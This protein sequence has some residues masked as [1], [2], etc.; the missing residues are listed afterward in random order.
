M[1]DECRECPEQRQL[2]LIQRV[3]RV[4]Y[5]EFDPT[6]DDVLLPDISRQLLQTLGLKPQGH[7]ISLWS[8]LADGELKRLR[9]SLKQ[10]SEMHKPFSIELR[11][12]K[13]G[14]ESIFLL[15]RGEPLSGNGNGA[16][17]E[18]TFQDISDLKRA[19]IERE[20]IITQFH[21]LLDTL[22]QGISVVDS[23]MRLI[24]WNRRFYEIL[25]FPQHLVYRNAPFA[26]LIRYNAQRG[27]YG[28]GDPEEHVE[29]IMARAA[30]FKPHRFERMK[31]GGRVLLVEGLPFSFG[32]VASGFV[33]C[34]TDITESK[35][36]EEIIAQQRDVM[37]VIIDNFPGG[38]SFCNPDLRFTAYNEQFQQLLEFPPELFAKGWVDFETL[39]RFNVER[40]EYGPGEPEEQ[41]K[42]AVERARNFQ[43][44]RIERQ[45]PNGKWLEIRGAPV[46][47]GGFVTSYIDITERKQIEEELRQ[48]KLA[49]EARREQVASLLDNADQGFLSFGADLVVEAECSR[50]CETM[51]GSWP[52]GKEA[53]ELLFGNDPDGLDLFRETIA[54]VLVETDTLVKEAMLSLLPSGITHGERVLHAQCKLLDKQRVMMVLTDITAQRAMATMLDKERKR[55]EL[56]VAAVTDGGNFFDAVE[57]YRELLTQ[58]LPALFSRLDAPEAMAR[59]AYRVIHTF[60]GLLNQFSFPASPQ[61]LH[62]VEGKL[63]N[64]LCEPN[65]TAERII[66]ATSI[67]TLKVHLSDDLTILSNALGEDFM[68]RG[69]G[70]VLSRASALVLNRL[71]SRLLHGEQVAL[72]EPGLHH[73]LVEVTRLTK[74]SL[75]R[76]LLDFDHF[77]RQIGTRTGKKV[78]RLSVAGDAEI[79]LDPDRYRPFLQSLGHIFRN[80]VV[81]GIESPD[82][83]CDSGKPDAALIRCEFTLENDTIRL[84]IAD[85]GKG[86][87]LPALR[88]KAVELEL[89]PRN[90][91]DAV[92]D[93]EIAQLIF[94]DQVSTRKETDELAG[95]GVGLPAVL[96]ET[97]QLGGDIEIKTTAGEGTAFIFTLPY[98]SEDG[99]SDSNFEN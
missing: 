53:A 64:L 93:L 41:V 31:T 55:Q 45:R 76:A 92:D 7:D 12:I 97:R 21:A 95:R 49:A 62:D 37:K 44:H 38:V 3:G 77:V 57:D 78:G 58:G 48:A 82:E 47:S 29:Q 13:Q 60:K 59:E 88:D 2:E 15:V 81:H 75:K 28:P 69:P 10:A 73:A 22:P 51:L 27:E 98:T 79:W 9:A 61:A 39:V 16:H 32:G 20:R 50:S 71:A 86:L 34:Y 65:L 83:R 11:A 36:S 80:A 5:W 84:I 94:R 89:Y 26:E 35:R 42:A 4:G 96:N 17:L 87:D 56:I 99:V 68:N 90:T 67:D 52:A 33:T 14:G 70:I 63:A 74:I 46:P 91:V 25:D 23:D 1:K 18:G 40:G 54:A 24:M 8:V 43:P 66:C 19:E 30:E 72:T 6:R 85:D